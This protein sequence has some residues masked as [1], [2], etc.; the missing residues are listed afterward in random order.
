MTKR[1]GEMWTRTTTELLLERNCGQ[2]VV[3][4]M[5]LVSNND[6]WHTCYIN[7]LCCF[8]TIVIVVVVT[9]GCEQERS[10][11]LNNRKKGGTRSLGKGS[12]GCCVLDRK[13]ELG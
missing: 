4:L 5:L 7:H 13:G 1:K 9:A 2:Q 10:W 11:K 6:A 12:S 3:P 8:E